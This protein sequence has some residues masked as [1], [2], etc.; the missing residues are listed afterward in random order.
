MKKTIA[1]FLSLIILLSASC[2]SAYASQIKEISVSVEEMNEGA[3]EAIE[4]YLDEAKNNASDNLIYKIYIPSGNYT[5]TSGLHIFS[6]TQLIL[7]ESTVLSKGFSEGNMLKAGLY[8]EGNTHYSGY[9][10]FKNIVV[11]GGVWDGVFNGSSC[12]MRFG[13]CTNLTI[14]NL[15]VKNI[16]NA[17]HIEV[18]AVDGLDITACTFS[19]YI[20]MNNSSAEALQIDVLHT[21][22]HF[23]AYDDYD[24]T[25]CKNVTVYGC[26]FEDLYSGVGTRSGVVGSYFENI[27]IINNTFRNI[28]EK[29]IYCFNYKNSEI[30]GNVINDSTCGIAFEYY[31]SGGSVSDKLCMPNDESKKAVVSSDCKSS[32]SN[33]IINVKRIDDMGESFGIF[34]YGSSLSKEQ[35]RSFGFTA[36]DFT[37]KNIGIYSNYVF[38]HSS[39]SRGIFLTGTSNSEIIGNSLT[40][41]ALANDGINGVNLCASKKNLIKSNTVSGGFNNGISLYDRNGASSKSN[42]LCSNLITGVQSYGV[43]VAGA[44][45]ITIKNTNN[46]GSCGIASLCV[47][48]KIID[49]SLSNVTFKRSKLTQSGRAELRWNAVPEASGYK[50][51]RS[52]GFGTAYKQ[53]ATVKGAKLMFEDKMSRRGNTY[54]YKICPYKKVGSTVIIGNAST[55][56]AFSC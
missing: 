56:Y 54:Y 22:E 49:M 29:A 41:Y 26:L 46:F 3:Y 19:G 51:Y 7:T 16:M 23:P 40:D 9:D 34:V 10:G 32:I 18:A 48:S 55:E 50:I 24:D 2:I 17:H 52:Y 36:T 6:N 25:P 27:K 35:A 38:C 14:S 42:S 20:R 28:R 15:T 53:I 21:K 1:F 13:H 43:R 4:K 45:G 11:S 37:V 31:P 33:N 44:S 30:S 5:L 12:A 39:E 8:D 47:S